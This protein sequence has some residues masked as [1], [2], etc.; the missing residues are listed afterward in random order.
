MDFVSGYPEAIPLRSITAKAVA[1]AMISI[2]A[3]FGV[4]DEVLTDNR[5]CFIG[6][7]TQ[8]LLK[9]LGVKGIRI[10]PYHP[11]SNGMLERWHRLLKTAVSK[12]GGIDGKWEKVLPLALFAC[13]DVTKN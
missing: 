7:L 3:R 4:P 10:S 9:T 6:R 1:D 5:S 2:F 8:Q 11:Q 13:R 12:L